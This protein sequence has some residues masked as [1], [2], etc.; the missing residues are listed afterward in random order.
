[1]DPSISP[2][3]RETV[4]TSA[5]G[6]GCCCSDCC[7]CCWMMSPRAR[8]L[9]RANAKGDDDVWPTEAE[10]AAPATLSAASFFFFSQSG[11]TWRWPRRIGLVS[12]VTGESGPMGAVPGTDTTVA[13]AVTGLEMT[14][15]VAI[16][17]TDSLSCDPPANCI[18]ESGSERQSPEFS[19]DTNMPGSNVSMCVKLFERP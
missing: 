5:A 9:Q 19:R 18:V 10:E 8:R 16:A 1:M 13:E 12:P 2:A 15:G 11:R 4:A 17:G 6:G 7:C 3:G 14:I